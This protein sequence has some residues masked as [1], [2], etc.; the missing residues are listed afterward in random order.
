LCPIR[1]RKE[2]CDSQQRNEDQSAHRKVIDHVRK[3]RGHASGQKQWEKTKRKG[4]CQCH[5]CGEA[6]SQN[7]GYHGSAPLLVV[8]ELPEQRKEIR[9]RHHVLELSEKDKGHQKSGGL[10]SPLEVRVQRRKD[11][12]HN[13]NH[14]IAIGV[15]DRRQNTQ[16]AQRQQSR[17]A[18]R[19]Q[20]LCLRPHRAVFL[21]DARQ[22]CDCQHPP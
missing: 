19:S 7:Y 9:D 3:T 17:Q 6:Q 21:D 4:C 8:L 18:V 1:R 20:R 2:P 12:A 16:H 15:F 10:S 14:R 5:A 22:I 11:A 13:P